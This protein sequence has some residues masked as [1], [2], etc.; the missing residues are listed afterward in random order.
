MVGDAHN[1]SVTAGMRRRPWA[2]VSNSA[3]A[4]ADV[5]LPAEIFGESILLNIDLNIAIQDPRAA[6]PGR[7]CGVPAFPATA[8]R[9][10]ISAV[11]PRLRV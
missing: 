5:A 1:S 4:A 6:R 2:T 10:R 9:C 7:V 3:G 8:R 11:E